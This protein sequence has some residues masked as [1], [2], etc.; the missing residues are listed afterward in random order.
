MKE[1]PNVEGL[2]KETATAG[3]ART[4]S[5]VSRSVASTSTHATQTET[6][7]L[8]ETLPQM[9]SDTI[10][11][12]SGKLSPEEVTKLKAAAREDP[13]TLQKIGDDFP[14]LKD[15]SHAARLKRFDW[16]AFL[17]LPGLFI[18]PAEAVS[19]GCS[20]DDLLRYSQALKRFANHGQEHLVKD[21]SVTVARSDGT[22]QN[23]Q[24]VEMLSNG[25][26]K[27]KWWDPKMID[28]ATGKPGAWMN[29]SQPWWELG[30]FDETIGVGQVPASAVRKMEPGTY[31]DYTSVSNKRYTGRYVAEDDGYIYYKTSDQ[32]GSMVERIKKERISGGAIKPGTPVSYTS[33]SNNVYSGIYEGENEFAVIIRNP[34]TGETQVLQK[35][36]LNIKGKFPQG[37]APGV[38]SSASHSG[39]PKQAPIPEKPPIDPLEANYTGERLPNPPVKNANTPENARQ[40]LQ[41]LDPDADLST[42]A[43][44]KKAQRQ[45]QLKYHPDLYGADVPQSEK[46]KALQWSQLVNQ[47]VDTLSK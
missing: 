32:P 28:P 17:N 41:S 19:Y 44:I 18:S 12:L 39:A 23:A 38:P 33:Y 40:I 31:L 8:I 42:A 6:K 29:R 26:V 43:G 45:L 4:A 34:Q 7:E 14:C 22:M 5:G 27:V 21:A 13:A 35:S 16:I 15:T 3:E 25:Q 11:A 9:H 46:A 36:R 30:Q 10:E 24:V 2:V 37:E 1:R 47:A 20:A